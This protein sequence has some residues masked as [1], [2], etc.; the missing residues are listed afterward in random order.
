MS[1]SPLVSIIFAVVVYFLTIPYIFSV[2]VIPYIKTTLKVSA[3]AQPDFQ[4]PEQVLSVEIFQEP[5]ACVPA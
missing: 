1:T 2:I 5:E 4:V 3:G